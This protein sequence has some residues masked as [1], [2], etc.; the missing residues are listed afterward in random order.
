MRKQ[1]NS[2]RPPVWF[3]YY[4]KGEQR[5]YNFELC[6][7]EYMVHVCQPATYI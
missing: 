5:I 4:Q 7:A 3:C 1:L 2:L 6:P